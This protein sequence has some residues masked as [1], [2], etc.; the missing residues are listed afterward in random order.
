M[1]NNFNKAIEILRRFNDNYYKE[2]YNDYGTFDKIEFTF[3]ET[4]KDYVVRLYNAY[5]NYWLYVCL[6]DDGRLYI[7]NEDYEDITLYANENGWNEEDV[8]KIRYGC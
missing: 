3:N 5:D 7:L 1:K 8:N 4:L 6:S 2:Y